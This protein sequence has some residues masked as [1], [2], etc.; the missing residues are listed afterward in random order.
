MPRSLSLHSMGGPSGNADFCGCLPVCPTGHS[1]PRSALA[2][3]SGPTAGEPLAAV[4]PGFVKWRSSACPV[5]SMGIKSVTPTQLGGFATHLFA[6][7]RL[8]PSPTFILW[9]D[10]S[11][12]ATWC[13]PSPQ[14]SHLQ[15]DFHF[16][17]SPSAG[18]GVVHLVDSG[19]C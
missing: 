8:S 4:A 19:E 13:G 6:S 9:L 7:H 15:L 16:A 2:R 18:F 1:R 5:P 12:L 11:S 10:A 17:L 14:L 3:A